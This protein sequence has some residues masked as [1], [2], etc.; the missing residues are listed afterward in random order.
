MN[1]PQNR[2]ETIFEA[3][4]QLPPEQRAAHLQAACGEDSRL[5]ERVELLLKSHDAAQGD[6]LVEP[7]RALGLNRTMVL[8]KVPP[9]EVELGAMIG[10]Y[11]LLEKLGEG[12]FG[13]VFVAEQR[14]PVKRRVALKVIKLGMDTKLVVARFEAERQAL[15]MM[16][17]PNIARVLDAGATESGRPYF[18]MELVRGI[19]ITD[20]CDQNNLSTRER[21]ELFTKVCQAIQ[22]AHQKGIIHR[23]VKP[24]NILV[25]LHD[26]VPVPKVIDFGIAKATQGE[27]TDKTVY[28]QLQEFIGTPAY[29]SPEQAEMS[30]LDIDTRSDIY[31]LGVLLYELLTGKTPFDQK[32]LL[33]AGIEGMRRMIREQEP[34]RPSTRVDSLQGEDR[35]ATAKCHSLDAPKLVHLLR[36]D[37]DW[38]V[39]KCLEKDRTRRYETANGLAMDLHRYLIQE[40]VVARPPS[41][42]YRFQKF[43]RRNKLVFAA[44][45]AVV[46]ALCLGIIGSTWQA[47]RATKE[48]CIADI[49][50]RHAQTEAKRADANAAAEAGQ[51]R[52]AEQATRRSQESLSTAFDVEGDRLTRENNSAKAL[53]YLSLAL[54]LDPSNR[55]AAQRIISLLNQHDFP[56]PLTERPA[57]V[58]FEPLHTLDFTPDL[59]RFAVRTNE[60]SVAIRDSQTGQRIGPILQFKSR[61]VGAGFSF[62]GKR[63][64]VATTNEATLWECDTGRKLAQ[65]PGLL[66]S[67]SRDGNL[68]VVN[69]R[70]VEFESGREF[71]SIAGDRPRSRAV[72][73]PDSQMVA[74]VTESNSLIKVLFTTNGQPV[75]PAIHSFM[76]GAT[77]FVRFSPE[78]RRLLYSGE[79][80]KMEVWDVPGH[81]QC[82]PTL[83]NGSSVWAM[84]A[85]RDGRMLAAGGRNGR[86]YLWSLLNGKLLRE[87]CL[88]DEEIEW[89]Y[90]TRDN[91]WLTTMGVVTSTSE[92]HWQPPKW[93]D[94]RPGRAVPI[95][96]FHPLAVRQASF[97]SD[98]SRVLTRCADNALRLWRPEDGARICPPI[99]YGGGI[100]A[101]C[102]SRDASTLATGSYDGEVRL[103]KADSGEAQASLGRHG[104]RITA[105]A[106]SPDGRYLASGAFDGSVNLWEIAS[107]KLLGQGPSGQDD[108]YALAVDSSGRR[109]AASYR[110]YRT[111]LLELP[112]MRHIATLTKNQGWVYHASFSPDGKWLATSSADNA[113]QLWNAETGEGPLARYPHES[114]VYMTDISSDGRWLATASYDYT[115]RVWDRETGRPVS[116][117]LRHSADVLTAQFSP[118]HRAVLTASRDGSARVWDAQTGR[119]L[120]DPFFHGEGI[121]V[122]DF[123][124][125]G[126]RIL[127]AG[128]DG[129]ATIFDWVEVG[130]QS[131]AWMPELAEAVGGFRLSEAGVAEHLADAARTLARLRGT[132]TNTVRAD[133]VAFW[134]QW[135]LS[136]RRTRNVSPFATI[137]VYQYAERL[138]G[139]S[140]VPAL[141]ESLAL[142]ADNAAV[143]TEL[144]DRVETEQ[145]ETASLYRRLAGESEGTPPAAA[146]GKPAANPAAANA[147]RFFDPLDSSELLKHEGETVKVRGRIVRFSSS[148]TGRAYYLNFSENYQATLTLVF[149][150]AQ[151]PT[152]LRPDVL[153]TY[154]NKTVLV[155]GRLS[156]Y[157]GAPQI[158]LT[159]PAAIK[160]LDSEDSGAQSSVSAATSPNPNSGPQPTAP[161]KAAP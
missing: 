157:R 3:A 38:I 139:V 68:A 128:I 71:F 107:A 109:L 83:E 108:V 144:A 86:V 45:S 95:K 125:D 11:K 103:W 36:G 65:L 41:P 40:P 99:T 54:R 152:E 59:R 57:S 55:V 35:T 72:F 80:G 76:V 129:V 122:A 112:T 102:F 18:V 29:M 142:S 127:T 118:N 12:G 56:L 2:E 145:P 146:R 91:S 132:L 26:G 135:Y 158:V 28:T 9:S 138:A 8:P 23:D 78:G 1:D 115:A 126:R 43:A 151:N 101:A 134:G 120:A 77:P 100:T 37:L 114:G 90:I 6:F 123:S 82:L 153:R 137:S 53:A 47:V 110:S 30:G 130:D 63:L 44:G 48:Q 34:M 111:E 42:I 155:A 27:L 64:S 105:L 21:L 14:E 156:T 24:S 140:D 124:P 147:V 159:S 60:T 58:P 5:R 50:R 19:R 79:H 121:C 85:S 20:Y 39:M 161:A 84:N 131:P 119:P 96:L 4:L 73:S 92:A 32:E 70:I 136:D 51:R 62:D 148:S 97:S 31:A 89:A 16:D 143:Y 98:G 133:P 17:H 13:V 15:A 75:L 141:E 116:E 25:T 154:A 104:S 160:V 7:C 150:P 67:I 87:P 74:Y 46:L 106:F 88:S 117:P 113:A 52:L 61:P 10:R 81:R 33:S 93:W 66:E 94:I 49:E 22:H 69:E 149:F